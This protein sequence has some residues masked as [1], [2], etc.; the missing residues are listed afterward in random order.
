MGGGAMKWDKFATSKKFLVGPPHKPP[1][2]KI[3][4]Y[5]LIFIDFYKN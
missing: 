5:K 2:G 4:I 3:K 1:T